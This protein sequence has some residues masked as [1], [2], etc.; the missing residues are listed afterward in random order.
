MV[1]HL[2]LLIEYKS[3]KKDLKKIIEEQL[4][5]FNNLHDEY[6]SLI[7]NLIRNDWFI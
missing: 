2:F 7:H 6:K 5:S 4:Q 1:Y 3:I